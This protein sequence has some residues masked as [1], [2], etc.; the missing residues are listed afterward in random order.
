MHQKQSNEL[1]QCVYVSWSIVVM[2]RMCIH[3]HKHEYSY[4]GRLPSPPEVQNDPSDRIKQSFSRSRCLSYAAHA[5]AH[6]CIHACANLH[7]S[8]KPFAS[9][10]PPLQ[11]KNKIGSDSPFSMMH[12]Y[13][14]FYLLLSIVHMCRPAP[15]SRF[16]LSY[17]LLLDLVGSYPVLSLSE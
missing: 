10:Q 16:L 9:C 11:S 14:L 13:L 8:V 5:C 6:K 4:P 1:K 17:S 12:V 3:E 7:T 15:I 2:T